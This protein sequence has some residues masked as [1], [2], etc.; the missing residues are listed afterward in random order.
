MHHDGNLHLAAL[1]NGHY[2]SADELKALLTSRERTFGFLALVPVIMGPETNV[3]LSPGSNDH[4]HRG[5]L[6][7]NMTTPIYT[8]AGSIPTHLICVV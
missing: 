4:G 2:G 6:H 3:S 8:L 7:Y 5:T 1:N